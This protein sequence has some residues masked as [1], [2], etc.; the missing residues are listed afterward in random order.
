MIMKKKQKKLTHLIV[1]RCVARGRRATGGGRKSRRGRWQASR[2]SWVGRFCESLSCRRSPVWTLWSEGQQALH[3]DH[4][5]FRRG[6]RSQCPSLYWANWWQW[7]SRWPLK[8]AL[9]TTILR[10]RWGTCFSSR[11]GSK[12]TDATRKS[13]VDVS[14]S[15]PRRSF[16][17]FR[18]VCV[19][20]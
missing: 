2:A 20:S 16:Y 3:S 13:A 6:R 14:P 7:C 10:N 1:S 9:T 4:L 8:A 11:R 18:I 15:S 5:Y 12:W 17:S 19:A